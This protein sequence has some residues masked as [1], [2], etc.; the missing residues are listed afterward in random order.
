MSTTML[1]GR[2]SE[3]TGATRK[4][5]RHYESIG[6]I[7]QPDRKGSY[8]IYTEHDV[9]VI[10]MI[11]RA[12]ALGFSLSEIKEIV[13]KKAEE[14]KLPLDLVYLLIDKKISALEKEAADILLKK[15]SL[16]QFK[17]DLAKNFP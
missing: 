2:V 17:L 7:T 6:L 8:R 12:K 14:K 4:A 15:E 11:C 13:A 10:S 5:I 9:I 1:I 16:R 3:L